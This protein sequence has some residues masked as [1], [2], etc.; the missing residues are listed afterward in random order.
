M[1]WCY[2]EFPDETVIACSDIQDDDTVQVTIERP[3]D[4]GFDAAECI[5]PSHSWKNIDGFSD[6]DIAKLNTFLSNN[7]DIIFDFARNPENRW[8]AA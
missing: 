4:G 2:A 1:L 5:L 3:R 6:H 7:E 8:E